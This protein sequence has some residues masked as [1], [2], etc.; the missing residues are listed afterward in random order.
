MAV[1][2]VISLVRSCVHIP[3]GISAAQI[4]A[5]ELPEGWRLVLVD[6]NSHFNHLYV[7]PRYAILP[8]HAHKAF[9]PYTNVFDT[10][11]PKDDEGVK[12]AQRHVFLQAQVTSLT[13]RSAT[14]SRPFPD[15]D[16]DGDSPVLH[17]DY[18][19]YALGSH[20][21]APIDLWGPVQDQTVFNCGTKQGGI[22]WL[23]EYNKAI[24]A[25][26]SILIVG[27]GALGIRAYAHNV[28]NNH[29]L[30]RFYRICHRYRGSISVQVRDASPFEGAPDASL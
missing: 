26:S 11:P 20:L 6:R 29:S 23:R 30:C 22:E 8:V 16:L 5:K 27:G 25:A 4:L 15:A 21:P 19:L 1:S 2:V 3:S 28:L 14:L 10:P 13:E 7:L 17:F 9:I 18:A 12:S 24:E